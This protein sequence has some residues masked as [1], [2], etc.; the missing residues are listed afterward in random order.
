MAAAAV[1]RGFAVVAASNRVGSRGCWEGADVP[2]VGAALSAWRQ[3]VAVPP[4]APLFVLGPSSGGW[5]AGQLGRAWPAVAAVAM[6]VMVP[7]AADLAPPLPSGRAYPPLQLTLLQRDGAKLREF[8]TLRAAYPHA[9]LELLK[10]AP[11]PVG[12]SF[13]SDGIAGLDPAASAAVHAALVRAGHVDGE[14]LVRKHPSRGAWREAVLAAL[15]TDRSRLPQRSLQVA[16][17]GIFARLDAAYAYHAS[18]CEHVQ[19]TLA[20]FERHRPRGRADRDRASTHTVGYA[21]SGGARAMRREPLH[22]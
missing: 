17:D 15:G 8:E 3:R 1:A 20:F 16:M 10:S 7:S 11:R 19:A 13:F 6:Q 4:T 14:G 18:T 22:T 21:N 12:P 9:Q 5:F 2:L